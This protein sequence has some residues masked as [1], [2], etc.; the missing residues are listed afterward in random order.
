M[1]QKRLSIFSG[2]CMCAVCEN[3]YN[4]SQ[5]ILLFTVKLL[6]LFFCVANMQTLRRA[7]E[8]HVPGGP[9]DGVLLAQ[10]AGGRVLHRGPQ[11]LLPRLLA[12]WTAS[13]GPAQP[14]PGSLHRSADPGHPPHDGT[15]G[16]E[17]QTQWGDC[18]VKGS[19]GAGS[20]DS[21]QEVLIG[22]KVA[23]YSPSVTK[24]SLFLSVWGKGFSG[25]RI[26][27]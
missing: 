26:T 10:Q 21:R 15:G 4:N 8:L 18:V 25:T 27:L 3:R 23:S 6:T 20:Q 5:P 24:A 22:P 9:E 1:F 7:D 19:R 2:I 13:Q 11:A 16:V 17:K 14:H 12:V